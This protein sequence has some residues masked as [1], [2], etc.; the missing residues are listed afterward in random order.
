MSDWIKSSRCGESSHCIEVREQASGQ[1][2]LRDRFGVG[3]IATPGE[4]RAFL[5]G[6]KAGDFDQISPE[7]AASVTLSTENAA[8]AVWTTQNRW[9]IYSDREGSIYLECERCKVD[10]DD[11]GIR[12]DEAGVHAL[13]EAHECSSA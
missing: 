9:N 4:W 11:S 6:A 13:I 8:A 2:V 10:I 5:A 12:L 1:I 7:T 3:I